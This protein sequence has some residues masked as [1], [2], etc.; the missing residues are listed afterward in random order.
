[1]TISAT[2]LFRLGLGHRETEPEAAHDTP[3]PAPANPPSLPA[4]PGAA[5]ADGGS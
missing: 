5:V 3:N 4:H 2:I 1:M